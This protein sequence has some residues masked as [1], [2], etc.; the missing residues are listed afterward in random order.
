MREEVKSLLKDMGPIKMLDD[1]RATCIR[2]IVVYQSKD[3]KKYGFHLKEL[4]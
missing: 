4:S 3:G 1:P 2:C